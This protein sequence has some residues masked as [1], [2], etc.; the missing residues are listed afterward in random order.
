[1]AGPVVAGLLLSRIG[2]AVVYLLNSIS[3]LAVIAAVLMIR[4]SGQ[5]KREPG[6]VSN[7]VSLESFREG[8]QFVWRTPIIVQTMVLDFV[9]TFF[10]SASALLPIYAAEILRVGPF[11]LGVLAS[12]Q[13]CGSVLTA[14]VL[15]RLGTIR[16]QGIVVILSVGVYGL[17]TVIFGLSRTFL[18]SVAMLAL[19]GSSDTVSTVL[20]QTIRQLVTPDSLRGRMTSVNM[21]FFMGG[22]QLGE[23]EAGVLARFCGA[24]FSVVIGGI[25]CLAAVVVAMFRSKT[26]KNYDGS[27]V[28]ERR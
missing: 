9:A 28:L 22:P 7:R 26:L 23:F 6:T 13:A 8:L 12:A 15:A 5:V 3:F 14:I 4:A 18:L 24:P 27:E 16:R 21:I 1:V 25:G 11:G 2:P 17:A 10:A 20:R 19:I